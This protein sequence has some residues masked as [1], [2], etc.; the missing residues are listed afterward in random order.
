MHFIPKEPVRLL[1]CLRQ[2]FPIHWA[3]TIAPFIIVGRLSF[4]PDGIGEGFYWLIFGSLNAGVDPIPWHGTITELNEDC[5]R[6][7]EYPDPPATIKERLLVFNNGREFRSVTM[8]TPST[9][10]AVWITTGR[11]IGKSSKPLNACRLPCSDQMCQVRRCGNHWHRAGIRSGRPS[12]SVRH[13]VPNTFSRPHKTN[14]LS[15]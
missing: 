4:T 9:P 15:I 10:T 11:R 8:Q 13:R 1:I 12:Y 14:H 6:V 5:T 2:P 7:I 3:A